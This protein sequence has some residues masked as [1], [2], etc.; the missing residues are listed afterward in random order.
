MEE[1]MARALTEKAKAEQ[2]GGHT[3]SSEV[4]HESTCTRCGGLMVQVYCLDVLGSIG[5][6]EFAA[7]RCVQ[8]G[9]VVD[10]VILLNRQL[11]QKPMIAE[12][13]GKIFPS[14]CV[15]ESR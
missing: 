11:G 8:C 13:A 1:I 4:Q 9:E 14:N 3:V 12:R 15:M 7:K 6:S 10:S 2:I 5:E